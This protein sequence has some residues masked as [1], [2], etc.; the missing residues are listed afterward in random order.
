MLTQAAEQEGFLHFS[1]NGFK[2]GG[3][4]KKELQM[5]ILLKKRGSDKLLQEGADRPCR[6]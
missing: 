2:R 4:N 3:K 5:L 1:G 6:I